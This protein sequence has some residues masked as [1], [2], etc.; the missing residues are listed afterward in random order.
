MVV[1]FI[2]WQRYIKLTIN[3]NESTYFFAMSFFIFNFACG[4]IPF[5]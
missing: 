3:Q 1:D 2:S 5:A 4:R